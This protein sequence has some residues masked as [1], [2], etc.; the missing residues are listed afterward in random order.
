V[1]AQL[2]FRR[3]TY[4]GEWLPNTFYAKAGGSGDRI[5][6]VHDALRAAFLG[7]IGLLL[8]LAGWLFSGP[9]SRASTLPAVVGLAG[10]LL[11][12]ATGGDWMPA[13]RLIVPYL[14]LVAVTVGLG[15]ARLLWRARRGGTGVLSAALILSAPLGL[16]FQWPERARLAESAELETQGERS[17]HAALADW[18]HAQAAPGDAVVLMDIGEVGYR[19]IEQ[20]IVDVT[21]LTDRTI[22]RSPG[23]FLDKHFDTAYLW[24]QRPAF[25]VLAFTGVPRG[26]EGAI[27]PHAFSPMETRLASDSTFRADFLRAPDP[28]DS[29]RCSRTAAGAGARSSPFFDGGPERKRSG[30]VGRQFAKTGDSFPSS[31]RAWSW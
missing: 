10:A 14:P 29:T 6:Y 21:G 7:D 22:G 13:A 9:P 17:G 27:A 28:A 30:S 26:S 31:I 1:L 25:I 12:L 15:W 18:L 11:P 20:R 16:A 24:S 8:A 3:F 5:A 4:D 23:P 19:C 2:A